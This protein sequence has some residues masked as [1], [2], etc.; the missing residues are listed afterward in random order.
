MIITNFQTQ[1]SATC[2]VSNVKNYFD[3]RDLE[4]EIKVKYKDITKGL[5]IVH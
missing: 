4:K 5:L 1:R 2:K 3:P